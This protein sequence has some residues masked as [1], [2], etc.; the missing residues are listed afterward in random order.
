[1]V[2]HIEHQTELLDRKSNITTITNCL[3]KNQQQ[4]AY[5]SKMPGH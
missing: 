2:A 3:E 4:E 5:Q 1:M